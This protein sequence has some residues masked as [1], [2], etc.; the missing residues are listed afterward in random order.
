MPDYI[1]PH[2][3]ITIPLAIMVHFYHF[4]F[5]SQKDAQRISWDSPFIDVWNLKREIISAARLGEGLDFD[6]KVYDESTNKGMALIPT[7]TLS[8][9]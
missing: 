5:K 3:S 7:S 2:S 8:C 9:L 4:K 1:F 6:L